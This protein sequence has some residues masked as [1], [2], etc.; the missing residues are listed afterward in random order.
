MLKHKGTKILNTTRLILRRF[1]TGD[2]ES[3]YKNWLC[4]PEVTKYLRMEKPAD[5]DTSKKVLQEWLEKYS[6]DDSFYRWGIEIKDSGELIG[7]IGASTQSEYDGIAEIGYCI[8]QSYWN[9]G[10]STEALKACIQYLIFEIGYNRIE[11]CHSTNNPASG[12]VMQKCGMKYEGTIRQGYLCN[13][14]YQ[15]SCLYGI[16]KDDFGNDAEK[17]C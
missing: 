2:A 8:G 10:Y 7:T 16:I 6:A 1:V 5:L 17:E 14:G 15:D 3:I 12:R 4:D 9:K 11:G 13:L